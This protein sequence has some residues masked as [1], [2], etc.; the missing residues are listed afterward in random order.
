MSIVYIFFHH[1]YLLYSF[2]FAGVKR[3]HEV[4]KYNI[5]VVKWH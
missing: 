3:L 4:A 5:F 1:I 2:H